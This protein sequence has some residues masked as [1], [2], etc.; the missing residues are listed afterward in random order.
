M[1]DKPDPF[2]GFSISMIDAPVDAD[3]TPVKTA[4]GGPSTIPSGEGRVDTKLVIVGSR[5]AGLNAGIYAR[6]RPT[7]SPSG[8]SGSAPG[9]SPEAE[10]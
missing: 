3:A 9:G 6:R 7:S 2:G 5:A 1:T 10:Q 4:P 8:F